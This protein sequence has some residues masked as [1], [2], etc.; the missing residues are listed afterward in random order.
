MPELYLM[1]QIAGAM[2]ALDLIISLFFRWDCIERKT[3]IVLF[4]NIFIFN[5]INVL[6]YMLPQERIFRLGSYVYMALEIV[7]IIGITVIILS[8]SEY[9]L[10]KWMLTVESIY[11][12]VLYLLFLT[13]SRHHL[14]YKERSVSE[15]NE[16]Q[17]VWETP[18]IF[19]YMFKGG[20]LFVVVALFLFTL[21]S[22]LKK[23]NIVQKSECIKRRLLLIGAA[24]PLIGSVCYM[25]NILEESAAASLSMLVE[26]IIVMFSLNKYHY[27]DVI[28]NARDMVVDTMKLALVIVDEA[29]Y[30]LDSN[31][32]AKKIYPRLEEV[33][34]GSYL[35]EQIPEI[36]GLLQKEQTT[37]F[38]IGEKSYECQVSKI[39]HEGK[40][41]GYALC[42][43]DVTEQ[44]KYMNQLVE[45]RQ[46][47]E[48][49]NEEKSLFLAN[50]SHE[51]R[52]P[53]NVIL[54]MSEISLHKEHDPEMEYVL[55]SIY[56]AGKGLLDMIN[57]ILD[58]SKIEAGK[59]ELQ[60]A[61][62]SL[63]KL[64]MDMANI[65]YSKL[66]QQP[67]EFSLEIA[68][69]VPR[70]L[71]G[72]SSKIRIVLTN[73]LGNA[74]KYTSE[75][76][77]GLHVEKEDMGGEVC[78]RFR[79]EDTGT[80]MKKEDTKHI[81]ENYTQVGEH[82]DTREK[83]T[84]LGL[85][86]TK[87]M[88]ELMQ[89]TIEVES[90]MG[91][92]TVFIVTVR[93]KALGE[94]SISYGSVSR[95][96][97]TDYLK[98]E[99]VVEKVSAS[100][101][102]MKVLVVDDV[103]TNARVSAGILELY[104]IESDIANS[105]KEAFWMLE[106]KNYDMIFLDQMMPV[107]DGVAMIEQLRRKQNW[108]QIPVIAVTANRGAANAALLKKSGFDGILEKPMDKKK[109]E[110]ILSEYLG[111]RR[112]KRAEIF[113]IY[114]RE[115][116]RMGSRL[117]TQFQEDLSEFVI[118]VHGIKGASRNVGMM[119]L[120]DFAEKMEMAGRREEREE[121]REYLPE[122]RKLLEETRQKAE[123]ETKGWNPVKDSQK[124][125]KGILKPEIL[126]NLSDA[127][128]NFD[129]DQAEEIMGNLLEYEYTEAEQKF[130]E[131]L[132][133]D[134]ENLDYE[135]AEEKINSFA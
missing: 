82:V 131:A 76:R 63:E 91:K 113:R 133:E 57:G 16:R 132:Q 102:G 56:N 61:P 69:G 7:F 107:M 30:Y 93:Q 11:F 111:Q 66:Y 43:Y 48:K 99:M 85:A 105:A 19:S 94:K 73:L 78:L 114:L 23:K 110:Q 44:R 40:M 124:R 72:D 65:V 126:R 122:F 12:I 74:M 18:G 119:E 29:F 86:I 123:S 127:L 4:S 118:S 129:L 6:G 15:I 34:E 59:M 38:S 9:P 20:F 10:P 24:I 95:E 14:F 77:I 128:G 45:L 135:K 67:V 28:Q 26:G 47:A 103:E 121:I 33:T 39:C 84:G 3:L 89:G 101:P 58:F 13:N 31:Q 41:R 8:M 108:D 60:E 104:Q 42:I 52:T 117:E 96:D 100:Y 36:Y 115:L 32:Y 112:E 55:K 130:L 49:K 68:E 46:K 75:G 71:I 120:G 81:F 80:G 79:I 22:Y 53:M 88:V 90:Q 54:G 25:A 1:V 27:L 134:M 97:V 64:L 35:P 2:L 50:A 37:D 83:G 70:Q 98:H 109:L 125:Q 92:G 116:D 106:K 51:I 21:I 62:Y 87:K 17:V 5:V